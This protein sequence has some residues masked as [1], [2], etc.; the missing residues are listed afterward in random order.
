MNWLRKLALAGAAFGISW[1]GA[2]WYWRETNRMPATSELALYM[3]VL[4]LVLLTTLWLGRKAWA[5]ISMPA[6]A[7]ATAAA[8][9][10]IDAAPEAAPLPAALSIAASAIRVPHG[11]SVDELRAA[12]AGNQARPNLDSELQ[13]DDGYPS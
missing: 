7:G 4:P 13:D 6:T 8:T 2:I 3:L 12:L 10:S 9:P 5:R 11:A 1:G